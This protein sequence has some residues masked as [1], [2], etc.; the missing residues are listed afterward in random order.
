MKTRPGW[1]VGHFLYDG[2]FGLM[3]FADTAYAAGCVESVYR[4]IEVPLPASEVKRQLGEPLRIFE[5][6][7]DRKCWHYTDSPGGTHYRIR[8]FIVS[9]DIAVEKWHEFYVD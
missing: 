8:A 6:S 1:L 9:G 4:A 5:L 3:P 2:P 7:G